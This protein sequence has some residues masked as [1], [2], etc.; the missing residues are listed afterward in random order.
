MQ[1]TDIRAMYETMISKKQKGKQKQEE[2]EKST[3]LLFKDGLFC[4]FILNAN[5]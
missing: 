5:F 2:K 4:A 1:N 3:V